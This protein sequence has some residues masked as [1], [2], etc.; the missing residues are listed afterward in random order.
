MTARLEQAAD[1]VSKDRVASAGHRA[2]ARRVGAHELEIAPLA[3][4]GRGVL[5]I[6]QA[7]LC[8]SLDRFLLAGR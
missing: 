3:R 6:A 2:R 1:R 7:E 8:R 4:G 5:F